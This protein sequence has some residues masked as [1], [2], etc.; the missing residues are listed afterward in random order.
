MLNSTPRAKSLV[1]STALLSVVFGIAGIAWGQ[2]YSGSLTGVVKD[3]SG[4]VIP[5]AKVTLTDVGKNIDFGAFTDDVGRYVIRALPP[6]TYRLKVEVSGFNT[7]ILEN[8]V[9]AVNQSTSIDVALQIG[10]ATQTVEV[11]TSG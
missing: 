9:L 5:R 11:V 4:A 3:A 2:V 10:A 8:V 6:S 1:V 7:Y